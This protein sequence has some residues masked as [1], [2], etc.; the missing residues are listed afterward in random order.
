[1]TIGLKDYESGD[2]LLEM[3][4]AADIDGCGAIAYTEFLA[5]TMDCRIYMR[6]DYLHMAFEQFDKDKTGKISKENLK[7]VLGDGDCHNHISEDMINQ[8]IEEIDQD[9]DGEISFEE[10]RDMMARCQENKDSGCKGH[11]ELEK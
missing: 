10:F 3:L 7:V 4:K 9:G 2:T 1:L 5:A 6:D 8:L 11:P